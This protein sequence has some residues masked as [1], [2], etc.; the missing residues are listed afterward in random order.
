MR[1]NSSPSAVDVSVILSTRGEVEGL[2]PILGALQAQTIRDRIELVI[3]I[4]SRAVFGANESELGPFGAVK[5]IEAGETAL[6]NQGKFAAVRVASAPIVVFAE[7]HC[8]PE[9]DWAEILVSAHQGQ[10]AGIG[11]SVRNANPRTAMSVAGYFMHWGAWSEP[12]IDLLSS[13]IAPHNGSYRRSALLELGDRLRELLMAEQFLQASLIAKGHRMKVEPRAVVNHTN[14]SRL[15]PWIGLGYWGGK[16]FGA[17]RA[18]EES[19][20]PLKRAFRILAAPAIPALRLKRVMADMTRTGGADGKRGRIV[21]V[22]LLGLII[23]AVGEAIGY[24]T[25]LGDSEY[26]YDEFEVSR[27]SHLAEGELDEM[28][29][30]WSPPREAGAKVA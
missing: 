20:S 12:D 26:R 29:A 30:R 9:P 5:I 1:E 6:N 8:F 17:V 3:A 15:R 21:L 23:H 19:W 13:G 18:R 7:D 27:S 4:R 24:A 10:F 22:V 25:G 14:I 16:L 11:P 28:R 2:R